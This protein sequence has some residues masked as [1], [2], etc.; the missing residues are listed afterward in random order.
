MSWCGFRAIFERASFRQHC[1]D[2]W[3]GDRVC[4]ASG[5]AG[6]R[7]LLET[8]DAWVGDKVRRAS[9]GADGRRLLE[10]CSRDSRQFRNIF[11]GKEVAVLFHR[12]V[13]AWVQVH[14]FA[15][16]ILCI[17]SWYSL[18]REVVRGWTC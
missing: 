15:G 13:H 3:V 1:M 10:H 14:L 2:T 4:R 11:H 6:G 12:R 16:G 9:S 8:A 5:R 7:R 18:F 17:D